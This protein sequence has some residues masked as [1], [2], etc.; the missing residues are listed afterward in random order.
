MNKK[1]KAI[2]VDDE[3]LSREKIRILTES[4]NQLEII[5]EAKNFS[6]AKTIINKLNPELLFLDINM[7]GKS[8]IELISALGENAPFVIFTTAHSDYAAEAFNLN[9]VHY[10]LKP[11]DQ[12][13]FNDAVDRAKERIFARRSGN[14]FNKIKEVINSESKEIKYSDRIPVKVQDKIVLVSLNEIY[15]IEAD[16]NYAVI[17][18]KE[19]HYR[20]RTTLNELSESL[21]PDL[22]VRVHKSYIINKNFVQELEPTFNQEYIIKLV[23]NK[24]IPT[25]KVYKENVQRLL[26]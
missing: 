24:K 16:K 14:I 18:L 22:F 15:F 5:G 12:Q 26:K 17:N 8:G 11:F 4:N 10:L 9:A 6:E 1:I 19:K 7:P 2:V 23:T 13:K 20:M 25:G 3:P 21:N